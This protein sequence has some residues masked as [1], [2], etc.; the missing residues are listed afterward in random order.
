MEELSEGKRKNKKR[1]TSTVWN[2]FTKDKNGSWECMV[3][4]CTTS[5]STSVTSTLSRHISH[6]SEEE[7]I[8]VINRSSRAPVIDLVADWIIVSLVYHSNLLTTRN[9]DH[10]LIHKTF[11]LE[12]Q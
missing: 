4:G 2:Y 5:Y 11:P 12:Y 9:S 10:Y 3:A 7:L 6:H 1:L 8:E